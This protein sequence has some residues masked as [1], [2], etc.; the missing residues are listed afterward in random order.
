MVLCCLGT[1]IYIV[2]TNHCIV[3]EGLMY[4]KCKLFGEKECAACNQ[5]KTGK[6]AEYQKKYNLLVQPELEH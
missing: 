1:L 3:L 4:L 5:V 2:C 6:L